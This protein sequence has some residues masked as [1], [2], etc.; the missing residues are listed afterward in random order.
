MKLSL[1]V[2]G[3]RDTKIFVRLSVKVVTIKIFILVMTIVIIVVMNLQMMIVTNV[4][5]VPMVV[6]KRKDV[7]KED[8]RQL[9][10]VVVH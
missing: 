6:T 2:K 1:F 10:S 7:T 8:L 4:Q 9:N 5:V 3:K